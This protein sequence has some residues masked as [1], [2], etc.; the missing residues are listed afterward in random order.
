M[1]FPHAFMGEP[2][3]FC[4]AEFFLEEKKKKKI[5]KNIHIFKWGES[6]LLGTHLT[7]LLQVLDFYN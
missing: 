5:N 7:I 2:K 1:Q 6:V 3:I 4:P